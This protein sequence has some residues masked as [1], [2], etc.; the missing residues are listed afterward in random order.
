MWATKA[1]D[2]FCENVETKCNTF[3]FY[4]IIIFLR[5]KLDYRK[6][7]SDFLN[8]KFENVRLNLDQ[9]KTIVELYVFPRI[10]NRDIHMCH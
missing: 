7:N 4:M 6:V 5:R 1:A 3:F 8:Y 9:L 2:A 10:T